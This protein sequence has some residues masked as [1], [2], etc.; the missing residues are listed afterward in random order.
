MDLAAP[1][2]YCWPLS[3]TPGEPVALHASGPAVDAVVTVRRIGTRRESVWSSELRLEALEMPDGAA[4]HGCGWPISL[5]IPTERSW[6]SGYYEV[7]VATDA[8]RIAHE[9]VA[10]FVVRAAAPDP[11]RPLLA[12]CTNTYNA[13]ND[14]GGRNL[15]EGGTQVSFRRPMANGLLRKPAGPGERVTVL[16]PPDPGNRDHVRYLLTHQFTQWGGSAGWPN[17]ELPFARWCEANGYELDY[18]VNADLEDPATLDGRRLYLSVGH[19][20]YWSGPMRDTVESFTRTGGNALFLSGNAAFWQVRLEDDGA[21]MV[22]F[23]DRFERDPVFG[24]ERQAEL[25]SMWSDVLVDRPEN[26]MTGV[27]FVRG[28]YHRIGRT[29]ASGAGGYTVY[30]P[31]H[32]VFDGTGTTYGDLIG[33]GSVI[34]GYECDG[35][36]FVMRDGRPVPTGADGTPADFRMLGLA[37]V[38]HFDRTNAPRPPRPQDRSEVEF[39]AWR[40][41]GSDAPDAVARIDRGHAVMGL[42]EPGGFVFTAGTTDWVWGLVDPDPTVERIT[43]NLMDRGLGRRYD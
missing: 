19:D 14:V 41:L 37:P 42:H 35:C 33:A 1:A 30:D 31:D 13:Y 34:V 23:K 4:A 26:S 5:E 25:T 8:G 29:V 6:R 10:F 32:W 16:H 43:R 7:A 24:T 20:E 18:A 21:T 28:G 9:A 17:Y 22:G 12:L 27:S 38:Q 39:I 40:A 11:D 3:V 36:E 2:A 15:Y